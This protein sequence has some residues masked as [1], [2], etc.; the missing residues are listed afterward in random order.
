MS[1]QKVK[2]MFRRAGNCTRCEI[3]LDDDNRSKGFGSVQFET[4]F[5]ALTAIAM[6]NGVEM[7]RTNRKLSVRL[8]SGCS[9]DEKAFHLE[10]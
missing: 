8:V 7:G 3:A 2:D 5:E 10:K 1:W 6:F 4:P 9:R